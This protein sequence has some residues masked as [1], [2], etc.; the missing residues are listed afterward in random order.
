MSGFTEV[1][2][3]KLYYQTAGSGDAVVFIPGWAYTTDLFEKNLP[4]I[5]K[6]FK[7][8]A[9][10]PRSH[11]RSQVSEQGNNYLQYGRDLNKLIK[12]IELENVILLG[13]SLGVTTAYSYFEQFG[14]DNVQAFI[15]VDE[16]PTIIKRNDDD[17]GEGTQE[18]VQGLIDHV[19]SGVYLEFFRE[20]MAEG[21]DGEAPE[22]LLDRFTKH[23]ESLSPEM[24]ASLLEDAARRDYS[25]IAITVAEKMPVLQILRKDWSENAINWIS[26]NQPSAQTEVLGG[27]LMVYEYAD[28]FNKIVLE[29]IKSAVQAEPA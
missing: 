15:S 13:W 9:Y 23:A 5:S 4:V 16:T 7:V 28:E 11:G 6:E 2:A 17:W 8:V 25:E 14:M 22:E 29:F 19:K 12:S 20:Y 3:C 24:A 10:D 18:E 26:Q 1:E 21:F 27:H